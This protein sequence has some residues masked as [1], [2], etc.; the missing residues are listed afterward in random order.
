MMVMLLRNDQG[1]RVYIPEY[2][3]RIT[4]GERTNAAAGTAP[5]PSLE[6]AQQTDRSAN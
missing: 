5:L 6:D 2:L 3:G 4:A 1:S